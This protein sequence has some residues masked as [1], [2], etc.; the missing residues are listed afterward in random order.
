M[1]A[2]G[3]YGYDAAIQYIEFA[4]NNYPIIDQWSIA[5]GFLFTNFVTISSSLLGTTEAGFGFWIVM[6]ACFIC[7]AECQIIGL[8]ARRHHKRWPTIASTCFLAFTP[9]IAMLALS[10]THDAV[11]MACFALIVVHLIEIIDNPKTYLSQ[12]R[13]PLAFVLIMIAFLLMRNNGFYILLLTVP[14]CAFA[15]KGYRAKLLL[16]LILPLV[17]FQIY[18]GPV[19]DA[20]GVYKGTYIGEALALSDYE[21][22]AKASATHTNSADGGLP[23]GMNARE[24]LSIPL[25]QLARVYTDHQVSLT[26]Q[27]LYLYDLY[28]PD[29]GGVSPLES[30]QTLPCISD[31]IK[32]NLNAGAIQSDPM[33][34]ISLYIHLG[35]Q[36]PKSY[37]E[38]ALLS[39]IGLWYPLKHY[40]D[41]R[42]YHPYIESTCSN[43]AHQPDE[44]YIVVESKSLFPQINELIQYQYGIGQENFSN[45]PFLSLL[46]KSGT[47]FFLLLF[48]LFYS[49]YK[50][51]WRCLLVLAPFVFLELS[52]F[53][54]PVV[55]YRYIASAMFA[56]PLLISVLASSSPDDTSEL[57]ARPRSNGTEHTSGKTYLPAFTPVETG[58]KNNIA[59]NIT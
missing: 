1:L 15:Q 36:Y 2:P 32:G 40:P 25:Q 23:T 47:Y 22:S 42:M 28:F 57:E 44:N 4:T 54:G 13:K 8:I 21:G 27:E 43:S 45:N 7:F 50:K 33:Q 38:A 16:I 5:Y 30:Y 6:Q 46:S 58:L 19:L 12:A 10:S 14:F 26:A 35:V 59:A 55:L 49:L 51:S 41:S 18:R 31:E 3:I 48:V 24:M 17:L 39:N 11:F 34:F 9:P 37:I 53:A 20:M 29:K 56:A 52:V